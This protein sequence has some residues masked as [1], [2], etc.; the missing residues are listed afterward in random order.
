MEDNEQKRESLSPEKARKIKKVERCVLSV[1]LALVLAAV[2][3]IAGWFGRWDALGKKKQSLLWAIDTAKENYYKDIDEDK[4]YEELFAA[5]N[6]D[7]YSTYYT[8]TEYETVEAERDGVNRDA[9]FSVYG[10]ESRLEVYD[11]MAGSSAAEKGITR[12]M[13]FF[14]FGKTEDTLK[15]G[16]A[17]DYFSFVANLD[18][19]EHYLVKC[20]T[21]EKEEEATVYEVV[22]GERG[23]GIS[24][25]RKFDP[26][27]V[28]Q[29][30]G[31]SPAELE[32]L[33]R[34]MYILKYGASENVSEMV[35][36][37]SSEFFAF[38][39]QLKPDENNR[40]TIHIQA[41]FDKGGEDAKVYSVTMKEYN[42]TYCYYRDN[43]GTYR[44]Q[45]EG[46][47]KELKKIEGEAPL[48]LD[49]KTA[50]IALTQ[51]TGNAAAEFKDCLK[52]MK[53]SGRK[54]LV[55]D[56]RGNGG[57]YM[58]VF[59]EIAAYLLKETDSSGAQRVAYAKFKN[60]ATVSYA[61]RKSFYKDYFENDSHISVLADEYTASASECLIGA[62]VDYK[63][64]DYSDIYLRENENGVARTYGK[65][66]M[67]TH[68][69]DSPDGG[70]L[71]LT[72]A[73]IFWPKSN[74]TIHDV[75]VNPKDGAVAI[76]S[77]L[78]PDASDSF[79]QSAV[80][81][82]TGKQTTPSLPPVVIL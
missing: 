69:D 54:N 30:V 14:K 50:Y 43:S 12:D 74:K 79:L 70:I 80:E 1:L 41:G 65:G 9:G 26:M 29:V 66:I 15:A 28:Y 60:G 19:D 59:V 58:D 72:S 63:T 2:A 73:E 38:V 32:G 77:T 62:L 44:F 56:L 81:K 40:V 10:E 18:Q 42:A 33:K 45:G 21:G 55:L 13:R 71:K 67:Q 6:F 4:F 76:P 64:I 25:T 11:V 53:D 61:A 22:N 52:K 31:N 16:T 78:L 47:E 27:R 24:L 7:R 48:A 49:D 75:G 82:I 5:F 17:E 35:S 39:N 34:G 68:Y 36:G 23:A 8:K 46:N 51:F 20:G 37:S 57:G 3:F